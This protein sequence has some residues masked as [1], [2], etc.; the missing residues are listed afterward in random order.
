V[1]LSLSEKQ[2][3]A[4]GAIGEKDF[5]HQ[6]GIGLSRV[7]DLGIQHS[8]TK[9]W[10]LDICSGVPYFAFV[11]AKYDCDFIVIDQ[12]ERV[13]QAASVLGVLSVNHTVSWTDPL[14]HLPHRF[15]VITMLNVD[16]GSNIRRANDY[17]MI[18][19]K[20]FNLLNPGG[21]LFVL[22]PDNYLNNI[23]E[24]TAWWKRFFPSAKIETPKNIVRI[25]AR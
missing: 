7:L 20:A 9:L 1:N 15:D 5:D 6:I 8:R 2:M 19:S 12:D 22:F 24:R 11:A 10:C 21:Q 17:G 3:A 16:L 23:L 14:P 18:A 13:R 25:Q 4:L